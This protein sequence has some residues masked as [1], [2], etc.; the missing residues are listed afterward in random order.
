MRDV[1]VIGCGGG[2]PVIA[3]ELAQRGLDV[4]VLEAGARHGNSEE[5]WTHFDNDQNNVIDGEFR[6]GPEDRD[7]SAWL[8]ETPQNSFVYQVAGVGGT[9]LHF[10]GNCPRAFPGTFD[11]YAEPDA[12]AYDVAHRFPFTYESFEPYYRWVE[13]T[14]PVMTNAMGTKE[15]VFFRGCENVGLPVNPNKD[16][17]FDSFR[18]QENCILQPEGTAGRTRDSALLMYPQAQGCTFCGYCFQGCYEPRRAPRNLKAKRSTDN[19]YVPMMLTADLWAAGG[20][21]VTLETDAYVTRI[22]S[23]TTAAGDVTARAVT[24][25]NTKTGAVYTE[26][27]QVIVM[28]GGC[29]ED[30]RLWK[31][32]QLPDPNQWVGRGMTDHAFDWLTGVFPSYTGHSKGPNSAAR[33]DFPGRGAMEQVGLTPALQALAMHISDSGMR[34]LYDAGRGVTGTWDGKSGR[35]VGRELKEVLDN[36]DR[37]MNIL[38]LTDDDVESVN[39]AELSIL[40]P[41][42]HGPIPRVV[43]NKRTRSARTLANREWLAN[44]AGQILRAAGATKVIRIDMAPLILHIQSSMRMGGD[45]ANSVLDES[46][47]ARWVKRLFIA[48]NSALPNALGGANPTLSTQALATRTAEKIFQTYFGGSPWVAAETPI[49]SIDDRVTQAVLSRGIS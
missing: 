49:S 47:E 32:S 8:R 43:M 1:I 27:A 22:V 7:R 4:L 5:E 35:P 46:C 39:R 40:P 19:S 48:D 15:E 3:K 41:D 21:A 36:V 30:P 14:L 6:V 26:E 34:G 18:P 25:R 17:R 9:T 45:P 13:A 11:G 10:Y 23:E 29:T 37:L 12:G 31:N 16:I 38:I 33:A 2:G 44:K 24:W 20:K 28:A 42:E